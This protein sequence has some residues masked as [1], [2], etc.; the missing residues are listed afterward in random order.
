MSLNR[1]TWKRQS[2]SDTFAD[3]IQILPEAGIIVTYSSTQPNSNRTIIWG[4]WIRDMSDSIVYTARKNAKLW[5]REFYK[6]EG[7]QLIWDNGFGHGDVTWDLIDDALLPDHL[8][9]MGAAYL[10][11]FL[12][13]NPPEFILAE[14]AAPSNP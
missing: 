13:S 2:Q 8:Q 11:K 14:Q 10:E 6:I 7:R 5:R 9:E 1:S 3:Y 12:A 4:L